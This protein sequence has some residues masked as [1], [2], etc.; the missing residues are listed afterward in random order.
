MGRYARIGSSA[1]R[2][3]GCRT[4]FAGSGEGCGAHC[5][6][7]LGVGG[8]NRLDRVAGIDRALE[9]VGRNDLDDFRDLCNVEKRC[10]AR[11]DVLA[12]GG[13][14]GDDGVIGAGERHDE[15]RN[16]FCQLMAI[17]A[18]SAMRTLATPAS[19]AACSPTAAAPLPATST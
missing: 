12:R 7:L 1:N 8:L 5:D 6:H 4:A 3:D 17:G 19:L 11:Q 13:G 2:L 16:R 14:C 15:G 9:R 10:D 18:S